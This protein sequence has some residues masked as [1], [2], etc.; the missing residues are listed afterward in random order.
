M[1]RG[2][3]ELA[4]LSTSYTLR[5][6]K[7]NK[8]L[9]IR[10]LGRRLKQSPSPRVR[11]AL[12]LAQ[13]FSLLHGVSHARLTSAH[14]SSTPLYSLTAV[15]VTL[16]L[17]AYTYHAILINTT[18]SPRNESHGDGRAR[19]GERANESTTP[20]NMRRHCARGCRRQCHIHETSKKRVVSRRVS[21]EIWSTGVASLT[22][23]TVR[24]ARSTSRGFKRSGITSPKIVKS[25]RIS[26][27][28]NPIQSSLWK[29]NK[30][31]DSPNDHPYSAKTKAITFIM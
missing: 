3:L 24:D 23:T 16:L 21:K 9:C 27:R 28:E 1:Q 12:T 11:L 2:R 30:T 7:G 13:V 25:N 6:K 17:P 10:K 19:F 20:W 5:K 31:R 18:R 4:R 22:K 15:R 14:E 29:L 8:K 26:H